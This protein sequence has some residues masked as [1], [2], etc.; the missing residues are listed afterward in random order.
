MELRVPTLVQELAAAGQ[1]Q[2][3]SRYVQ[4]ERERRPGLA[5][6]TLVGNAADMPE[7][8]PV[9][10]LRGLLSCAAEGAQEASKL[11]SALQSCYFTLSFIY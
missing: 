3:P 8:V 4:H 7:P 2:P 1:D 9:I 11:R 10:D 5:G 6:G